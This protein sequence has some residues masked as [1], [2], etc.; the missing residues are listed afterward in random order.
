MLLDT[1]VLVARTLNH[2]EALWGVGA[3]TLLYYHGLVS[4]PHDID[5]VTSETDIEVVA[6]TLR[7]LGIEKLSEPG[8]LYSTSR[9]LEYVVNG[10]DVDVMAGLAIKHADGTYVLPF[11]RRS[12]TAKRTED[13]VTVPLMSLED[14]YVVYQLIPGREPKVK[15][16]ED[17]ILD[18]RCLD[19]EL[20][21]RELDLELPLHVRARIEG[22]MASC[23]HSRYLESR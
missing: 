6:A 8:E 7:G 5:I 21:D 19:L 22:L 10:T 16:I 23:R 12:I 2:A 3:S 11:D 14:W 18:S 20:L 4:E 15:L 17:H 13:G 9:F 1:L